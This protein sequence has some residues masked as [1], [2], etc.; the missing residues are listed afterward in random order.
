M[1]SCSADWLID[2]VTIFDRI[3]PPFFFFFSYFSP[4]GYVNRAYHGYSFDTTPPARL[5]SFFETQFGSHK[6]GLFVKAFTVIWPAVEAVTR[7]GSSPDAGSVLLLNP[8]PNGRK[9]TYH[10]EPIYL[11][12][13][14]YANPS[15]GRPRAPVRAYQTTGWHLMI[16]LYN[17]AR[18]KN[19]LTNRPI[20][21]P[22]EQAFLGFY[23]ILFF[24][25]MAVQEHPW[26]KPPCIEQKNHI[27]LP[28][29]TNPSCRNT[30]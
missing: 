26:D 24:P 8:P 28:T 13:F 4:L 21:H 14:A 6:F 1:P 19:L 22:P 3:S 18:D 11:T 17:T 10:A 27:P 25:M 20:W 2:I 23:F 12:N 7:P 30:Q 16:G 29:P 15:P 9:Y 5:C